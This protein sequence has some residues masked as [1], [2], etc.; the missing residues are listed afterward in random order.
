M[1]E[2]STIDEVIDQL[3]EI[4]NWANAQSSTLG[5]FPALYRRVTIL[6]KQKIAENH[7]DDGP[8]ME[9]LDVIFANRYIQAFHHYQNNDE[10][11]ESWRIAFEASKSFWPIV[12]Q[13]LLLGMNA[14]INLDLGIASAT[15]CPGNQI[16][17][18]KGDFDKINALLASLVNQVED[19]LARVWPVLKLLDWVG[20]RKDEKVINFS[21]NIARMQAWQVA[22]SFAKTPQ[23]EWPTEITALDG[24]IAK[25]ADKVYN[26]GAFLSTVAGI[27]RIGE[28]G[29][30][31]KKITILGE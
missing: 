5:Y 25:I 10:L 6:V 17:S 30:V 13:H 2:A 26:P 31:Q 3:T 19:Q 11:T 18:L 8:R 12:L 15:V 9:K 29:S 16:D 28:R 21:I 20:G 14:H 23:E 24:Q 1:Q 4:I 27:I 22:K 7:F